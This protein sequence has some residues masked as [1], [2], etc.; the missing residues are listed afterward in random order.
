MTYFS[1]TDPPPAAPPAGFKGVLSRAQWTGVVDFARAVNAQIVISFATG[2]GTRDAAGVW[3]AEQAARLVDYTSSIGGRIAAAEFMN[4][5]N[6]ARHGWGA[7][8]L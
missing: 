2:E 1:A 7:G 4:E 3:T 5:P 8:R 6:L